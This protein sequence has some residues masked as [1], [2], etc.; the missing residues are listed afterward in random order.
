[1]EFAIFSR[2]ISLV[3]AVQFS[4]E[5]MLAEYANIMA[6]K[7]ETSKTGLKFPFFREEIFR[8]NAFGIALWSVYD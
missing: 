6:P 1:M 8:W 4:F 2:V 7:S 5:V 3:I